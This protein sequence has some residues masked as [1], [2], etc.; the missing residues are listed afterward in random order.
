M[1]IIIH[2]SISIIHT[3]NLKKNELCNKILS[4]TKDERQNFI[5]GIMPIN[6][7][8]QNLILKVIKL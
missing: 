3:E 8:T 6:L 5:L 7:V 4:V 2:T 1:I